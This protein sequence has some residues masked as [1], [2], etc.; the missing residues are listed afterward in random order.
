MKAGRVLKRAMPLAVILCATFAGLGT[1]AQGDDSAWC[2]PPGHPERKAILDALRTEVFRLHHIRVV[3]VVKDLKVEDG[4]AWIHTLPQSED[5]TQHYEDVSALMEKK[6]GSWR[7]AELACTEEDN[8]DCLGAP[9]FFER[10]R[11]RHPGAPPGIFP[12]S[13]DRSSKKP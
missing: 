3:F 5:D 10:L 13:K 9:D 6:D 11:E 12:S 2:P 1:A 7:V 8:P 4:W